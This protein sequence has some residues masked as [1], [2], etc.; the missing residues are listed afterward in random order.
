MMNIICYLKV[1]L[2]N[3][4]SYPQ[5][6][7]RDSSCPIYDPNMHPKSSSAIDMRLYKHNHDF[8][9]LFGKKTIIIGTSET[10]KTNLLKI[11]SQSFSHE[12]IYYFNHTSTNLSPNFSE[13]EHPSLF[14]YDD[15]EIRTLPSFHHT[16]NHTIIIT[17]QHAKALTSEINVCMDNY[18]FFYT[19]RVGQLKSLYERVGS[20]A[21]KDFSDFKKYVDTMCDHA[22]RS[23]MCI[24]SNPVGWH[25][26][27]C[28][29]ASDELVL[30]P[31]GVESQV[32]TQIDTTPTIWMPKYMKQPQI[33][34]NCQKLPMT[35]VEYF[36]YLSSEK[37][38][39]DICM[40]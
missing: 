13:I 2:L 35:V 28:P 19:S 21:F 25:Y 31:L 34:D 39:D 11:V 4:M 9:P 16:G 26:I 37:I 15:L 12:N 27:E 33:C 5:L 3:K 6:H 8:G 17:V 30:T 36:T 7:P 24:C 38:R 40:C 1:L 29:L 32:D 23:A 14:L 22:V 10:G 20:S 18:I